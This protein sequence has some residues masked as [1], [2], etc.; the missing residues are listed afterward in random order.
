MMTEVM[1]LH[2]LALFVIPHWLILS[3]R[4]PSATGHQVPEISL[5]WNVFSGITGTEI[6]PSRSRAPLRPLSSNVMT[7]LRCCC[8]LT[9]KLNPKAYQDF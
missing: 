4:G 6:Y 5:T 9:P 3:S 8:G 2:S 7:T 1:P